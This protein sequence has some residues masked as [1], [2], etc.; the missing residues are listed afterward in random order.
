MIVSIIFLGTGKSTPVNYIKA[1]KCQLTELFPELYNK[2]I[3]T[4]DKTIKVAF[5]ETVDF[6]NN[7]LINTQSGVINKTKTNDSKKKQ[8]VEDRMKMMINFDTELALVRQMA[9]VSAHIFL[10]THLCRH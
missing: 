10:L 4:S 6:D 7:V 9:L 8:N 2:K 1:A 5:D 3:N